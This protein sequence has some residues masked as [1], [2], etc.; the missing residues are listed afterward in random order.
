MIGEFAGICNLVITDL[1]NKQAN[2]TYYVAAIT[3]R[4]R[5]EKS[6]ASRHLATASAHI[7]ATVDPSCALRVVGTFNG[8]CVCDFQSFNASP[9]V[10]NLYAAAHSRKN[11]L[12]ET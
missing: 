8:Y 12:E 1:S 5:L 4:T 3:W 10:W 7:M 11:F 6:A 9:D 2:D